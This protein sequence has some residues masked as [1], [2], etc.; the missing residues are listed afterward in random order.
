MIQ[1]IDIGND[2]RDI[3]KGNGYITASGAYAFANYNT[4]LNIRIIG[5]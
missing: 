3:G 2:K 4:I 5:F 1:T